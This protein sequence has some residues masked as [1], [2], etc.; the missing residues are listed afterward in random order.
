MAHNYES[1]E[2]MEIT[3]RNDEEGHPEEVVGVTEPNTLLEQNE[4]TDAYLP[5]SRNRKGPCQRQPPKGLIRETGDGH[6]EWKDGHKW[7]K[8]E[9]F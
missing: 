6:I 1:L 7:G 8:F 5:P 4:F 3:P 2:S 9:P